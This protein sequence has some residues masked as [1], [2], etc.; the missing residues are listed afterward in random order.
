MREEPVARI[1]V[2]ALAA[3]RS[4]RLAEIELADA[5]ERRAARVVRARID[6]G[7]ALAELL[8]VLDPDLEYHGLDIDLIRVH[9]LEQVDDVLAA[10]GALLG[11][12]VRPDA[13]IRSLAAAHLD[14]PLIHL[15]LGL[16]RVHARDTERQ[17][18]FILVAHGAAQEDLITD[19]LHL[20]VRQADGFLDG[21]RRARIAGVDVDRELLPHA[22]G[23]PD[24]EA[25]RAVLLRDDVD[26]PFADD[27]DIG[28]RGIGDGDALDDARLRQVVGLVD[29]EIDG[30]YIRVG[31]RCAGGRE[32]SRRERCRITIVQK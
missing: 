21:E 12:D 30:L 24:G 4:I 20:D 28:D 23:R 22:V 29:L 3:L 14:V 26:L 8:S 7:I 19:L 16:L 5:P 10:V 25:R 17:R 32:G 1:P 6:G 11:V 2:R 15:F 31:S 9:H 13:A 27:D 18:F